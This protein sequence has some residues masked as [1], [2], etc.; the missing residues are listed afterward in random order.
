VK[1]LLILLFISCFLF[2]GCIKT[3]KFPDGCVVYTSEGIKGTVIYAELKTGFKEKEHVYEY[4]YMIR[5]YD[6]GLYKEAQ[7]WEDELS[8]DLVVEKNTSLEDKHEST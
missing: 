4:K 5:I 8:I 6:N 7:F 2:S 1:Y 3:H